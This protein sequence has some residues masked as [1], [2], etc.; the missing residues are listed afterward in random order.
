MICENL[1]C[2][3][4]SISFW[5]GELKLGRCGE[6]ES[7]TL[8]VSIESGDDGPMDARVRAHLF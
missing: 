3:G 6:L 2:R 8:A 1:T 7:A 4:D 5:F